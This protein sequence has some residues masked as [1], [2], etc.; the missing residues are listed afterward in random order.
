[1]RGE[2]EAVARD[3]IGFNGRAVRGGMAL[4]PS[5]QR[6]RRPHAQPTVIRM[7]LKACVTTVSLL[8]GLAMAVVAWPGTV[9]AEDAAAEQGRALA[10]KKCARCHAIGRTGDS[11][12]EDAPPFR[13]IGGKYPV[14]N[15]EEAFA[16]G[17]VVGHPDMPQFELAP[18]RISALLA[19]IEAVSR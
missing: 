1:M 13:T 18:D 5:V 10:E 17:I 8:A 6:V 7:K 2:G 16:E 15:L 19:H 4:A 9:Q 11:A 12:H 3:N 14:E